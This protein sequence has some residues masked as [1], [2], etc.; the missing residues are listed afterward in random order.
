MKLASRKRTSKRK[1]FPLAKVTRCTL[2][3]KKW[4]TDFFLLLRLMMQELLTRSIVKRNSGFNSNSQPVSYDGRKENKAMNI[5]LKTR[6]IKLSR[7]EVID[8]LLMLDT[9]YESGK[10]NALHDKIKEQLDIQDSKDNDFPA[11]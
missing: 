5:N 7:R 2:S 3:W 1:L 4:K 6:T 11:P 8:L 10:W 9:N